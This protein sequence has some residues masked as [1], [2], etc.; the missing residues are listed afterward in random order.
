MIPHFAKHFFTPHKHLWFIEITT[1]YTRKKIFLRTNRKKNQSQFS[2]F[3]FFFVF[4]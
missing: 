1:F 2:Y 3:G 4:L